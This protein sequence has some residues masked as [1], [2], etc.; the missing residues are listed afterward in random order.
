MQRLSEIGD[1]QVLCEVNSLEEYINE[2]VWRMRGRIQAEKRIKKDSRGKGRVLDQFASILS[3]SLSPGLLR[4][5]G[6]SQC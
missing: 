5:V 3:R 6:G 2:I 4:N 1:L